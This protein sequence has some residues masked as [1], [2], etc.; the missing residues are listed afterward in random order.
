MGAVPLLIEAKTVERALDLTITDLSTGE[1]GTKMWAAIARH[2]Q[3]AIRQAADHPDF[4]ESLKA[5][6]PLRDFAG[7][8][9]G[10]PKIPGKFAHGQWSSP[11]DVC[12]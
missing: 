2:Q 1:G 10:V 9:K 8:K 6:W 11:W 12:F 5:L 4:S 7:Q 3:S